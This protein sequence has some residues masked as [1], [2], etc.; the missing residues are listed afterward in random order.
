MKTSAWLRQR[1]RAMQC[2]ASGNSQK[3]AAELYQLNPAKINRCWLSYKIEGSYN[4]RLKVDK[5]PRV[6]VQN[7]ERFTLHLIPMAKSAMGKHCGMSVLGAF[8]GLKP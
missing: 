2:I 4:P 1:K 3:L 7:N 5:N 8:Y 6:K